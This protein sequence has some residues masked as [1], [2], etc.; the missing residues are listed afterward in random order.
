MY[1]DVPFNTKTHTF[2][3]RQGR[4]VSSSSSSSS[5]TDSVSVVAGLYVTGWAKRGATGIIGSNI[6]DARETAESVWMDLTAGALQVED[7][8]HRDRD[9]DDDPW[10]VLKS[11]LSS[12]INTTSASNNN[13]NNKQLITWEDYLNIDEQEVRRGVQRQPPKCR[14]KILH[15]Q[16]MIDIATQVQR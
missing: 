3:H 8:Q 14:D 1:I 13:S 9:N 16:D 4:I 11:N 7:N 2:P 6:P 12:N 10:V 5:N 15:T